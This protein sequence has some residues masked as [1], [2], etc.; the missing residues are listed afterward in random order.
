[1]ERAEE[2]GAAWPADALRAR[3]RGC[4]QFLQEPPWEQVAPSLGREGTSEDS[5]GEE[6]WAWAAQEG[7]GFLRTL[8][9]VPRLRKYVQ[10]PFAS[11]ACWSDPQQFLGPPR[12][13]LQHPCPQ[14]CTPGVD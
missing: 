1:M 2:P 6:S 7:V 4:V 8:R 3:G 10:T 14:P 9:V 11:P 13:S 5:G 12:S